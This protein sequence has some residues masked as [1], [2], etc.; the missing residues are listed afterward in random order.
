MT[1]LK[2]EAI[3][4]HPRL[5]AGPLPSR[6][7][8]WGVARNAQRK[9]APSLIGA[10]AAVGVFAVLVAL[11]ANTHHREA[12][13]I[14]TSLQRQLLAVGRSGSVPE[15]DVSAYHN[16]AS[17]DGNFG[18]VSPSALSKTWLFWH[19]RMRVN[20]RG[21]ITSVTVKLGTLTNITRV[22]IVTARLTHYNAVSTSSYFRLISQGD[23]VLVASLNAD[24]NNTFTPVWTWGAGQTCNEV[25]DCVGLQVEATDTQASFL[26]YDSTNASAAAG[27]NWCYEL[28]SAPNV[29]TSGYSAVLFPYCGATYVTPWLSYSMTRPDV[30]IVG[31]SISSGAAGTVAWFGQFNPYIQGNTTSHTGRLATGTRPYD[32]W[33]TTGAASS[34]DECLA[35]SPAFWLSRITGLDCATIGES[36]SSISAWLPS[37]PNWLRLAERLPRVAVLITGTNELHAQATP[38][39]GLEAHITNVF[40][41]SGFVESCRSIGTIPVVCSLP[42]CGLTTGYNW[43]WGT[44]GSPPTYATV[45]TAQVNVDAEIQAWN[46]RL[47]LECAEHGVQFVDI[48]SALADALTFPYPGATL[49]VSQTQEILTNSTGGT[50]DKTVADVTAA[51]DQGILNNDLTE[52]IT[53]AGKTRTD[54][55]ALVGHQCLSVDGV[56]PTP[57]GHRRIATAIAQALSLPSAW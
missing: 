27:S 54:V 4:P 42:P 41:S 17:V 22:R 13:S 28:G 18:P 1:R 49:T 14:M 23:W 10:V 9:R 24:A 26:P 57:E 16:N 50:A 25:G 34:Y 12:G 48:Y 44:G 39:V 37:Q 31:D 40:G 36:G 15:C 46:R 30:L 51:F 20:S 8:S 11:A 19:N 29:D 55:A 5:P 2:T 47:L 43:P 3:D 56:H 32:T 21:V 35:A 53:Q 7:R 6:E 45:A 38:G 33:V 52:L